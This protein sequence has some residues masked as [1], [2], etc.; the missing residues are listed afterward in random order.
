MKKIMLALTGLALA[1]CGGMEADS[2]ETSGAL[3]P[4]TVLLP[5]FADR[6]DTG[7]PWHKGQHHGQTNGAFPPYCP[8]NYVNGVPALFYCIYDKQAHGDTDAVTDRDHLSV[9]YVPPWGTD[10]LAVGA[11]AQIF[12]VDNL[13]NQ[14]SNAQFSQITAIDYV[15]LSITAS[16]TTPPS[17]NTESVT[18]WTY[19]PNRQPPAKMY[20]EA[21][22]PKYPTQDGVGHTLT[23]Q[24]TTDPATGQAFNKN[25]VPVL[26]GF[27]NGNPIGNLRHG[28]IFVHS[29][30][31]YVRYH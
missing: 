25:T 28:G 10:E 15:E 23:W 2:G 16:V 11:A 17:G 3:L 8:L 20:G 6:W 7:K 21:A 18:P 26:W 14:I 19:F 24:L 29:M 4:Q 1:G 31:V 13:F 9:A 5:F 27:G 22:D 12:E 30:Q